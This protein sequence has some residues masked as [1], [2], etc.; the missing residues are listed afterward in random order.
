MSTKVN[1]YK[2][3][4]E[5]NRISMDVYARYLDH[6]IKKNYESQIDISSFTPKILISRFLPDKLKMRF[7]RFIEYPYQI[8]KIHLKFEINH[9]IDHGYSHLVRYPLSKRNTI[10]TVH[11][12]I[13]ILAWK[14]LIPNFNYPHRPRLVDY[15]INSLKEAAHIVAVS[16]NTKKD[17]MEHCGLKNENISVIYNGCDCSFKP[18][19]KNQ[20]EHFR[21]NK[22]KFPR[23][24]FLILITGEGYKNHETTLKVLKELR[25][26]KKNIYLVRLGPKNQDWERLKNNS[27]LKQYII[28][29]SGLKT[30]EVSELYNSV[31]CL[32][33]PSWYEGFG[34]PPLEAMANGLPVVASNV[35]SI[36]EV[37]GDAGLLYNPNDVEGMIR[38]I[39]LIMNDNNIKTEM[40]KKGIKQSSNFT[41]EKSVEKLVNVYR[42]VINNNYQIKK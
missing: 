6:Y 20:K 41:W 35:A 5:D 32:L 26:K 17:L 34:L 15:S 12:I 13:P 11:D 7:A 25:L 39:N 38:G 2:T 33:F 30:N 31:D 24:S 8:K 4:K 40:I 42:S 21:N 14:G 9:I 3:F 29:L 37:V 16:Q 19:P 27:L 23:D 1:L 18:L 28:E 10:V 22:F 36:P